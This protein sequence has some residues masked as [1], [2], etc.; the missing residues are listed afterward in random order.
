M[1][2]GNYNFNFLGLN[3][4]SETELKK[5]NKKSNYI[6][7]K[8]QANNCTSTYKIVEYFFNKIVIFVI[9]SRRFFLLFLL[10]LSF[11]YKTYF[12]SSF[13]KFDF[14]IED[15]NLDFQ[16]KSNSIVFKENI[17]EI[18]PNQF[19]Y[20]LVYSAKAGVDENQNF[21]FLAFNDLIKTSFNKEKNVFVEK[22][23]IQS[24]FTLSFKQNV[25]SN[26]T[27]HISHYLGYSFT[28]KFN[29]SWTILENIKFLFFI[30]LIF[31]STIL[32]K[33]FF[34]FLKI[35]SNKYYIEE[36]RIMKGIN[37]LE[38]VSCLVFI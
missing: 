5:T 32:M 1:L 12:I 8:I 29:F 6:L 16:I 2:K 26:H 20:F 35:I 19:L 10:I 37:Y 33:K 38:I 4:I 14:I 9:T 21:N 15:E 18:S 13:L 17:N 31:G 24:F 27:N 7:N 11:L 25:D 34:Y 22:E 28:K 30:S 36:S 3:E 23:F